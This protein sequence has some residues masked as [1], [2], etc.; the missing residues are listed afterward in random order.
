MISTIQLSNDAELTL[1]V[2]DEIYD[3]S[4]KPGTDTGTDKD[5]TIA[6][7]TIPQTGS[8]IFIAIVIIITIV[9]IGSFAYLRY[10]SIDR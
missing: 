5:R 2:D 6:T 4:N 9:G 3:S 10:R 1:Y 7:G 8:Q